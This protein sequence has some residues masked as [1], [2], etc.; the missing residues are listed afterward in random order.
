MVE[1]GKERQPARR[2]LTRRWVE[3]EI[4]FVSEEREQ[5][6]ERFAHVVHVYGTQMGE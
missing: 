1:V 6:L 3:G 5:G 2:D 4:V